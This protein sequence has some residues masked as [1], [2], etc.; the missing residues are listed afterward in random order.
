MPKR[1][2]KYIFWT[3]LE[4]TG[5]D[6]VGNTIIEIGAV[7]TDMSLNALSARQYVI[8]SPGPMR[9]TAQVVV[10][11]HTKN[12]LWADAARSVNTIDRVDAEIAEW[13]KKYNGS[14]HMAFAGSGVTHFDRQ[15]IR[16]DMPLT[17][18]SL[19]YWALDVGAVR[20]TYEMLAGG[21]D[22]PED[23]KTH[24]ALGDVYFH[25]EEMR[26]VVDKFKRSML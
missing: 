5:S 12:G 13:I 2:H 26:F 16:R 23:T 11:M 6:L 9:H 18:K 17:D 3:D 10:D 14:N 19:T 20:R 8:H 24:R 15:F 22:W 4:T 7:I 21:T 1:E 25:I